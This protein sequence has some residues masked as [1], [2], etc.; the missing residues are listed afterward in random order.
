MCSGHGP[1]VVSGLLMFYLSD[2]S[3]GRL[4]FESLLLVTF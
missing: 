3:Y 2:V 4:S 1:H